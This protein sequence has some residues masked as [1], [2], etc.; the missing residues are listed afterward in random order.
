[1][2]TVATSMASTPG[3]TSRC[4]RNV[5]TRSMQN[6]TGEVVFTGREVLG[7]VTAD[8]GLFPLS[9]FT[10]TCPRL[11]AMAALFDRCR[12]TQLEVAY[13][14]VVGT[15]SGGAVAVAFDGD[16]TS[17]ELT[18]WASVSSKEPGISGPVW[19][20]AV[21][22]VPPHLLAMQMWSRRADD[23]GAVRTA[24]IGTAAPYSGSVWVRYSIRFAGPIIPTGV[25]SAVRF[26]HCSVWNGTAWVT[27]TTSQ[28]RV[29]PVGTSLRLVPTDPLASLNY[30][31]MVPSES[32][33]SGNPLPFTAPFTIGASTAGTVV[34]VFGSL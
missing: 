7:A 29:E 15:T 9:P 16:S 33:A 2:S 14:P 30:R 5:G 25:S 12:L 19:G 11:R 8:P 6:A 31:V 20:R 32:L 10:S 28:V 27:Q 18:D 1:M 24:S 3:T 13:E 26:F 21:F 22:N 34:T 4:T 23:I 17:A